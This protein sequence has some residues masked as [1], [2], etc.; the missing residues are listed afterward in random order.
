[1]KRFSIFILGFFLVAFLS[2][3]CAKLSDIKNTVS[4]VHSSQ[5]ILRYKSKY[6]KEYRKE[7]SYQGVIYL[8]S[9]CYVPSGNYSMLR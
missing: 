5:N 9:E 4:S 7:L 1:M 6:S 8:G 2:T 3:A